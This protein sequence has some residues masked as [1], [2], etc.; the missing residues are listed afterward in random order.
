MQTC[1][2]S[3]RQAVLQLATGLVCMKHLPLDFTCNHTCQLKHRQCNISPHAACL[4]C[5]AIG[6]QQHQQR[7]GSVIDQSQATIDPVGPVM[8]HL[9]ILQTQTRALHCS[10]LKC[11]FPMSASACC[12]RYPLKQSV[13]TSCQHAA[14]M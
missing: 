13:D 10:P 14:T 9:S 1:L 4:A 12:A 6:V 3:K 7:P 11:S 5:T 2:P 8:H